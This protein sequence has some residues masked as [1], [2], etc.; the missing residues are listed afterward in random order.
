M[1]DAFQKDLSHLS[2]Q[3]VYAR[4]EKR[5]ELLPDWLDALQVKPGDHVLDIGAGPGYVSLVLAER[6][7]PAG[8]IY[9]ID[10]SAEALA[11]LA[12]LQ[13]ERG[14]A[15]IKRIVGD[16]AKLESNEPPGDSA[17]VTLVLHH[18]DEPEAILRS[19]HRLLRPGARTL[20]GEFHPDGPCKIGAPKQ[21]RL[22]PD[23][24]RG[25]CEASGF[26]IASYRR[27]TPEHY[28]LVVERPA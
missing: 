22:A 10:R 16:A 18:A 2:W 14:V 24:V 8:M 7:G 19:V 20:I 12:R 6:V 15:Q 26:S 21:H 17:L 13:E 25:W 9:A 11:F 28:R 4:Q 5:A 23:I 3:E 1:A 27:Q